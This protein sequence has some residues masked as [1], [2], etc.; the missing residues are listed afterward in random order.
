M[1]G[2]EEVAAEVVEEGGVDSEELLVVVGVTAV[3]E[4]VGVGDDGAESAPDEGEAADGTCNDDGLV[5][6][7]VGDAAATAAAAAAAAAF[8]S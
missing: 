5:L 7:F 2:T 8:L 6:L 3:E 1:G 4:D